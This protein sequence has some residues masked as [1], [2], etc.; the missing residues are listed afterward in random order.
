MSF[1]ADVAHVYAVGYLE[2][3]AAVL[4]PERLHCGG[5][6]KTYRAGPSVGVGHHQVLE[7]GVEPA[8]RALDA[9][10]EALQ[11]DAQIAL[12]RALRN[13]SQTPPTRRN[14]NLFAGFHANSCSNIDAWTTE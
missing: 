8:V 12:F 1:G 10:I 2:H 11:A 14:H 13:H 4:H 5:D 7:E 9:G 6:G 3:A